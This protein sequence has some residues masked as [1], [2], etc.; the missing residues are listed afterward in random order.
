M[1]NIYLI[2]IL[3]VFIIGCDDNPVEVFDGFNAGPILF[4]ADTN[5]VTQLFS[6]ELDGTGV[7][8]L[9]N[10]SEYSIFDARWS[11]NGEYIAFESSR[12]NI[13]YYGNG[14][15]LMKRDGSDVQR[16]TRKETES[17]YATGYGPVWSKDSRV[18]AYTNLMIPEL[19]GN[20]NVFCY[21]LK[22]H[23]EKQVTHSNLSESASEWLADNETILVRT[24]QPTK[25]STGR[26]LRHSTLDFISK[27]GELVS[28]FGKVNQEWSTPVLSNNGDKL[29]LAIRDEEII[30]N[31]YI[32]ELNDYTLK[33]ITNNEHKQFLCIAWGADDNSLL[34]RAYDGKA[35]EYGRPLT[36]AYFISITGEYLRE[37][38][39]F[40][41]KYS[42][43]TSLYE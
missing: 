13:P 4:V 26:L 43:I 2:L 11:P 39:P 41:N 8:L 42:R 21:D 19:Y 15:F 28:S 30:S 37:I 23:N 36:K 40:K 14:L 9:T 25:D 35:D 16:I 17:Y 22:S 10:N 27:A 38:T 3:I 31:I 5:G 24:D 34:I 33:K 6:M 32:M 29:A 1:K 20:Y 7:Q 12:Y 18:I